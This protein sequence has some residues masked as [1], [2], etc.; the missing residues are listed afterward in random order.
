[1]NPLAVEARSLEMDKTIIEVKGVKMELDMRTASLQQIDTFKVGDKVKVLK[2]TASYSE[3]WESCPGV[4]VGFDAYRTSPTII[5]AYVS[6]NSVKLIHLNEKAKDVEIVTANENDFEALEKA[7]V[8]D[9]M[10]REIQN[11]EM[12][13]EELKHRKDYFLKF[14]GQYIE[15]PIREAQA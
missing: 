12:K 9:F 5:I 1:V 14:F 2:K 6:S 13:V 10:N 3:D 8:I 4:I 7:N 15:K 11:A